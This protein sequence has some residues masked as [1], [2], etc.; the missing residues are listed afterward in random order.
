MPRPYVKRYRV[1]LAL[2]RGTSRA[3]FRDREYQIDV[4]AHTKYEA[5]RNALI[6]EIGKW[7]I[8]NYYQNKALLPWG[9]KQS[10]WLIPI[11]ADCIYQLDAGGEPIKS[12]GDDEE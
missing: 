12:L 3:S 5:K 11:K 10:H 1:T 8:P 4:W 2:V 9:N 7:L 6:L